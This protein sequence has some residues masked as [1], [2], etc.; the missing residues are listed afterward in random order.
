[1]AQ[2]MARKSRRR[3]AATKSWQC[4]RFAPAIRTLTAGEAATDMGSIVAVEHS[5]ELDAIL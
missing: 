5:G 2:E 3:R 4:N 1:M